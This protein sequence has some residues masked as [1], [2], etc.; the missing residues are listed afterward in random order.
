MTP[1]QR[2]ILRLDLAN[3]DPEQFA[4]PDE[5]RFDRRSGSHLA[6]GGGLHACVAGTL[7]QSASAAATAALLDR[8]IFVGERDA[9]P[10]ACF[11]VRYLK[12]LTTSLA[13]E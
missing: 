5:F 2:V 1:Q 7:I 6:F 9:V 10:A 8:G 13:G 3:R 11:G 4:D 12:S